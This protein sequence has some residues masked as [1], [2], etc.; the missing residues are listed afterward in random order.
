MSHSKHMYDTL[1]MIITFETTLT[2]NKNSS[3]SFIIPTENFIEVFYNKYSLGPNYGCCLIVATNQNFHIRS[4]LIIE[5]TLQK[6][7][8]HC[9]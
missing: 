7:S 2:N 6:R 4:T 8:L 5:N 1:K 3:R 9:K